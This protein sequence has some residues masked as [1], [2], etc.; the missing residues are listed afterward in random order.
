MPSARALRPDHVAERPPHLQQRLHLQFGFRNVRAPLLPEPRSNLLEID[1]V[2]SFP[3][4]LHASSECHQWL[5]CQFI[6]CY[7]KDTVRPGISNIDYPKYSSS[8]SV[9]DGDT[10]VP[11]PR[12]ILIRICQNLF[13]LGLVDIVIVNV[14]K[15]GGWIEVEPDLH[16]LRI[17]VPRKLG[18]LQSGKMRDAITCLPMESGLLKLDCRALCGL[19]MA[20]MSTSTQEYMEAIEHLPRGATLIL[21]KVSWDDYEALTYDLMIAGRH[22]RVS[23]DH[24]RVEIVSPLNEH[25][26]YCRFIDALVRAYAEHL[27]VKLEA[28][29]QTTWR[30]RVLQQGLEPDCCYYVTSADRIIG[31]KRINLD[32]DPTPDI[33]VEI[34]IT[35]DS[36]SEFHIYAALKEPPRWTRARSSDRAKRSRRSADSLG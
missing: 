11:G 30:R 28:V 27:N 35:K 17:R 6:S 2:F 31:V 29:G 25:E 34:D 1:F 23:Y 15:T 7:D 32:V 18:K 22:A 26:S 36:L 33:A 4:F 5:A 10:G 24:G 16:T 14:R 12:T 8:V 13:N 3:F 21:Q 20:S 19:I 9:T